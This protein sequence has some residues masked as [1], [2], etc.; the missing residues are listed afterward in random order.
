MSVV[1]RETIEKLIS[2]TQDVNVTI[3]IPTHKKG[4]EGKQDSIR[5]KNIIQKT[6]NELIEKG[7][8][9]NRVDE[10]FKPVYTKTEENQ[11][12]LHQDKGL[13]LYVNEQYF[14]FFK[15]PVSP[16]ENFYISDNFLITP[17]LE[18]QNHHNIYHVLL[19]SQSETKMFKVAPD[20]TTQVKFESVPTSMEEH[21]K[22]H[23]HERSVQHHTGTS[24][25]GAVFH[26]Q[27]ADVDENKKELELFLKHIENKVT[28][29]LKRVNGPL[30]LA[31]P[32]KMISYYKKANKYFNLLDNH[33]I[34]NCDTKSVQE[35]EEESWDIVEAYFREEILSDI[36]R[37]NDLQGS[38]LIST[39]VSDIVKG[40]YFG[41]V[42][43]LFVPM[44]FHQYGIFDPNKNRVE[45][46]DKLN[47]EAVDLIN[48]A[49][50]SAL[51]NGSTLYGLPQSE[52]PNNSGLAAIYRYKS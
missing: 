34:G 43:T 13:A 15:I 6:K 9:E 39:D 28:K 30:V 26:G 27:G 22:Y 3:F 46:S 14:D 11:F 49:A 1:N 40:A 20:E 19:L 52:V 24:G 29:Y 4:E 23:V 35:I 8:K 38:E 7:W 10:L 45:I 2:E 44:G 33:I 25:G 17:L 31:G 36:E 50:I 12:W 5:L 37:F 18:L 47:G 32:D 42:D 48:Y 21:L 16:K 51:R 41:K